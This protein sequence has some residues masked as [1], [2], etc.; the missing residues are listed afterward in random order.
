M[1]H[2]DPIRF[3][4][5][6]PFRQRSWEVHGHVLQLQRLSVLVL[7]TNFSK[8]WASAD[9][10]IFKLDEGASTSKDFFEIILGNEVKRWEVVLPTMLKDTG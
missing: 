8:I 2:I 7:D 6:L 3:V 9:T 10:Q 4:H 1:E 5:L